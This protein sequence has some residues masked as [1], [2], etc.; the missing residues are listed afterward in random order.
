MIDLNLCME[1]KDAIPS[2]DIQARLEKNLNIVW[3][4]FLDKERGFFRENVSPNPEDNDC[5]EGRLINPGHSLEALW[6]ILD[7][8]R[9]LNKP[10]YYEPVTQYMLKILEFGWDKVY[11]GIFYFLD[12]G[13]TNYSTF[14]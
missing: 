10:E 2:I 8:A 12:I 1:M 11:G 9:Y 4:T 6:F 14:F 3:N 13:K 5:F 7:V